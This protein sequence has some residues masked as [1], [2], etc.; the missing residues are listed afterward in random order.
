MAG[1]VYVGAAKWD[2]AD[3]KSKTQGL[4]SLD[5]GTGEWRSL[6]HGLPDDVEVRSIL[7]APDEAIFAGT[8]DGPYRS[9]DGGES[10]RSLGLEGEVVW[11]I[12]RHPNDPETL[13]VGAQ[14][15]RIFRSSDGGENWD[16]LPAVEP[17]GICHMGFP[18][19]VID[20]TLNPANP[21][22]IYAGIEVGGVLR[23][24]D[25]GESWEDCCGDL[26]RLAG[27][28]HLKSQIG[29]DTDTEGMMDSHALAVSAERP[30]TVFLATR[31]GLFSSADKGEIWR[32]MGIGRFSDLTYARD[33]HVS[34]H[35]PRVMYAALSIAA[36]SDEGS[37]YRSGDLGESWTRFD[38][39]ISIHSTLM[40][41]A[42]SAKTPDR[43]Y[44]AARRGQVFGTEDGGE[45]WREFPLPDGVEGV[46]AVACA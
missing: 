38:R 44:C 21:D 11:S 27:E 41:V 23:S 4:F 36:A 3:R 30:G 26:L 39:D 18:S 24:L 29:S 8:Q 1:A 6:N 9:D 19:R 13:Y 12:L 22:E 33:L 35:D 46:Y 5:D 15:L 37:L 45:T 42:M 17:A 2:A 28:E 34:P 40:T 20:M 32:E 14:D 7:L 16:K 31:M 25:G 10:W 43:V